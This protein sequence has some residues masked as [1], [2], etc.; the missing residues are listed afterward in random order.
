MPAADLAFLQLLQLAD[1]ALPIGSQAH[2]FGLE[3]LVADG[4]VTPQTLAVFL[5][6]Y[7]TE[8]GRVDGFFC[9]AGYRLRGVEDSQFTSAWVQLND[10][11]SALRLARE[12]RAA[13]ASL[14][15]R[16]LTLAATLTTEERLAQAMQAAKQANADLHHATAFGLVGGVLGL[17]EEAT[18]LA[19]LQQAMASLLAAAQKLL[20][21]GQSQVAD[22]L[23]RIKPTLIAVARASQSVDQ[24]T[25]APPSFGFLVELA[26]M[27]H[28]NQPVRLFVS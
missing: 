6:E 10:Q 25:I 8:L 14:G 9:R 20:P 15:R 19:Y 17:G 4:L 26:S 21:V 3:S 28:P 24:A 18:V 7:S 2:S 13:S 1:S 22:L 5:H 27:R 23:W 11:L 12:S 16:L